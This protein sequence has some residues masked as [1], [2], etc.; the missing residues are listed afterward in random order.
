M[1]TMSF[2]RLTLTFD[3]CFQLTFD[4]CFKLTFDTCFQLTSDACFRSVLSNIKY[5]LQV[6]CILTLIRFYRSN[7]FYDLVLDNL[8]FYIQIKIINKNL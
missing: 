2:I 1:S 7:L 8:L 6:V 5:P 4:A 3:A